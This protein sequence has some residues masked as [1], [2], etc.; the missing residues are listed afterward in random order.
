MSGGLFR[1]ALDDR[2]PPKPA[3]EDPGTLRSMPLTC[4]GLR[5]PGWR[6]I[7]TARE[8]ATCCTP[9]NRE[10]E[11]R[12]ARSDRRRKSNRRC[13]KLLSRCLGVRRLNASRKAEARRKFVIALCEAALLA[14]KCIYARR[15]FT[16]TSWG[17]Q[18]Y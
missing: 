3:P 5:W 12:C 15:V 9:R 17:V 8:L 2:A 18:V 11:R 10:K 16:F 4:N 6:M 1:E 14:F 7:A 13:R